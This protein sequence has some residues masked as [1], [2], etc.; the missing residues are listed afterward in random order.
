MKYSIIGNGVAGICA[1]ETIRQ[2]DRD[3]EITL[4]GDETFLPYSRPMISLVLDGSIPPEKLPIRSSG[5]YDD[6]N[7]TPVLG[8]RVSGIDVDNRR[9]DIN[10]GVTIPYDKLL[11]ATGADARPI[12]AE[13]ANLKN[14][15]YMRT[16]AHVRHMLEFLPGA[17]P[18]WSWAAALWDLRRH[19]VCSRGV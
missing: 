2:L 10:N 13:G 16:E 15:F 17:K 1:A 6:L 11:I 3:G 19:T 18:R 7:I 8:D 14:I 4:I 12:K 9:L 5:F